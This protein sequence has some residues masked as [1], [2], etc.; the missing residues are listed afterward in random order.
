[1]APVKEDVRGEDTRPATGTPVPVAF[2]FI[3]GKERWLELGNELAYG[4]VSLGS[5]SVS[6]SSAPAH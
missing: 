4:S 5:Y 2:L 6:P 1:M 3:L